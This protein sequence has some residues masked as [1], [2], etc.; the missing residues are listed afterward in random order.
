MYI[1]VSAK[2][3]ENI[4]KLFKILTQG[5]YNSQFKEKVLVA[6]GSPGKGKST[7]MNYIGYG[8]AN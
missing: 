5:I 1:E 2:T 6:I 4:S 7:I 8:N 3:G